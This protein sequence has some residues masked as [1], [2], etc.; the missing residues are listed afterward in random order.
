MSDFQHFII[1]PL[2]PSRHR[3]EEFDCGVDTAN[4][5]LVPQGIPERHWKEFT[6]PE[7]AKNLETLRPDEASA[8]RILR[9]LV[10]N[11]HLG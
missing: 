4:Q 10:K 9:D 3:R 2:D 8:A 6:G 11:Q 1:E 7:L 5:C